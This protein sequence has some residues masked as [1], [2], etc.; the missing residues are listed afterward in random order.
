MSEK[1]FSRRGFISGTVLGTA[2]LAFGGIKGTTIRR[3]PRYEYDPAKSGANTPVLPYFDGGWTVYMLANRSDS[4]MLSTL[5]R[6]PSGRLVMIDGGSVNDADFLCGLLKQFGGRV[7]T[8]FVTHA[9]SDHFGALWQIL[10]KP[11]AGGVQIGRIVQDLL[12]L[13]FI[14]K[15]EKGTEVLAKKYLD[16]VV[17]TRQKTEKPEVGQ[18]FDFGEGLVFECLNGYDL[19]QTHNPVNDSSICYRV[20]NGGKRLLVTGDIGPIGST[21]LL[22]I[23]PREKLACDVLFLS[24]HGQNGATKEFYAATGAEICVWPATDWI[25]DDDFGGKG[26]GCGILETNVTKVWMRELKITRQFLLCRGDVALGPR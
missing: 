16:A 23:L 1:M 20:E 21:R 4:M 18:R 22:R 7:D 3:L 14:E 5:F 15:Y 17:R 24:H 26:I 2:S 6:S 9:H 10:E 11:D 13:D 19:N 12:P 25:W 8:W